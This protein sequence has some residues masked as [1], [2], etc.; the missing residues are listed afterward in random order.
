MAWELLIKVYGLS[1]DRLYVTYFKGDP[2]AGLEPDLEAKQMWL[3]MGIEPHR[4]LGCG[5]KENFWEMGDQGPCGPCSEI[6]YDRIGGRDASSLVNMDDPTVLEIWNLVFI[7]FNREADRSLRLLPSK[8]IDTGMGLERLVSVLQNKMSNYD[9]DVFQPIFKQ[10][11]TVTGCREYTGKVGEEDTDGVD[12]A[13]RV[14]ADHI[15]TLTFAISDGGLPSNEGRGYVLRRILRRGVRYARRRLG[16]QIGTFFSSLV[17]ALIERM[18]DD[19]PEITKHA[20]FVKEVLN[21]E[22]QSFARTLDRGEKLFETYRAKAISNGINS[23]DGE[24]VWRLYDTYGFPPD[25][26]ML[27]ANEH[28]MTIDSDGFQKAQEIAKAT[29]R[30]NAKNAG[31]GEDTSLNVHSIAIIEK[32]P[33]VEKTDDSSKYTST[34]IRAAVKALYLKNEFVKDV[35][36][37]EITKGQLFGVILDR[38]NFYSESGGQI[39]DTGVISSCNGTFEIAVENTQMYA[40]Y[41]LHVGYLKYGS[42]TLNDSVEAV[43]DQVTTSAMKNQTLAGMYLTMFMLGPPHFDQG[44]PY[45]YSRIELWSAKSAR[46]DCRSKG[47]ACGSGKASLRFQLLEG[48][49]K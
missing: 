18:G 35:K 36:E 31:Q 15:R 22:E 39:F 40:G 1:K 13:Y 30:G 32:D 5:A 25:L 8:H 26:T 33:N 44:Q 47:I 48:H 42:V 12:M 19:F 20:D 21:D 45:W 10:I 24:D 27:M 6:H 14:I 37:N 29:S 4:V 46:L 49:Y 43:Y 2:A 41:V 23:I 28:K 7:Q 3:D 11:Q 38:T 16:V 17:D 9:T 34:T